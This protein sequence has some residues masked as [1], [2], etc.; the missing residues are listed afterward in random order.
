[1]VWAGISHVA[2]TNHIIVNG[3]LNAK[4]YRGEILAP[5]VIPYIQANHNTISRKIMPAHTRL[6]RRHSS[7]RRITSML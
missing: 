6:D 5:F 4:R 7:Y 1:M 3:N 2:K